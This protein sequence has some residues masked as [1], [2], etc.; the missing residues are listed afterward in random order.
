MAL[1][2]ALLA[3]NKARDACRGL[4]AEHFYYADMGSLYERIIGLIDAGHLA[5]P[6]TLSHEFAPK[7]LADALSNMVGIINAREYALAIISSWMARQAIDVGANLVNAAYGGTP[8]IVIDDS[9]SDAMGRL[10]VLRDSSSTNN[11][12]DW[13]TAALNVVLR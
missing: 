2:G 4:K 13:S 6:V 1:I 5:N 3:N 7:L 11:G 12:P 9:I 10:M 8:G